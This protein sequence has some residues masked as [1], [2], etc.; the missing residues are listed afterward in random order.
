M[1]TVLEFKSEKRDR[2]RQ[3][4]LARLRRALA[5]RNYLLLSHSSHGERFYYLVPHNNFSPVDVDAL[6]NRLGVADVRDTIARIR[7]EGLIKKIERGDDDQ[8]M[9][10]LIEFR[11][12]RR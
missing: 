1:G 4:K 7:R 11:E 6:A 12:T 3:N 5:A 9:A 8:A 2:T 10:A